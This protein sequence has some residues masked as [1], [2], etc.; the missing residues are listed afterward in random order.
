MSRIPTACEGTRTPAHFTKQKCPPAFLTPIRQAVLSALGGITL[1]AVQLGGLQLGGLLVVQGSAALA[2]SA[3]PISAHATCES[4][5]VDEPDNDGDECYTQPD[6]PKSQGDNCPQ[7]NT[8]ATSQPGQACGDPIQL[9]I[10]NSL[11]TAQDYMGAGAFPISIVRTYNSRATTSGP[12]GANWSL[13]FSA[14]VAS[15]STTQVKV[16]SDSGKVLTFNL[17]SGAWRPDADVNARLTQSKDASGNTSGWLF[18]TGTDN[19]D[20]FDAQGRLIRRANRAGLAQTLS[21][22]SQGR[23]SSVADPYGRTLTLAYD[24]QNRVAT[25]KDPSS[26]TYTYGYDSNNNLASVTYPDG[27]TRH[28]LYESTSFPHAMT[29]LVDENGVRFATWTYNSQGL[30]VSSEHAGG[31]D[32]VGINYD[33]SNG[34]STV[35]DALS[36]VTSYSYE[37]VAGVAHTMHV[38]QPSPIGGSNDWD[39]DANGNVSTYIDFLGR[40]TAYTYDLSR[41]LETSRT[42]AQGTSLARTITTTWHPTLRLP[43][44]ISEPGR[45][46]TFSYDSAGNLLQRSVSDSGSN[47]TRTWTYTYN[48]AGQV[49][50]ATDPNGNV[51]TLAYD[52]MGNLQSVQDALGHLTRYTYDADGRMTQ[53]TDPNGL[54]T[55]YTYDARGRLVSKA[56]GALSTSYGYDA[57]GDMTSVKWPSGYQITLNYDDAHR[58]TRVTDGLG[59]AIQY[60]LDAMSNRLTESRFD[61]SGTQVYVHNWTYDA[62]NRVATEVGA[63]GQTT[64]YGRDR[65]GNLTSIT[66]PLSHAR[67]FGYDALDRLDTIVD[68]RQGQTSIAHD[69]LNHIV[70]VTDPRGLQTSYEVDALGNTTAVQSPDT[71]DTAITHDAAGNVTTRTDAKGQVLQYTYDALNRVTQIMRADTQQLLVSY[72]YD[73]VDSTHTNGIG[74]LTSM[75]DEGGTTDWAYDVN[76]HVLKHRQTNGWRVQTTSYTYD[77][78]SGNLLTQTLPSAAKVVYTWTK[79]RVSSV[80]VQRSGLNIALMSN[81]QYQPFGPI[82]AWSWGNGVADARQY[83]QDGRVIADSVDSAIHYDAASRITDATLKGAISG[84]RT[85]AYDELDRLTSLVSADGSQNLSYSYDASGNRITSSNLG[86]SSTYAVDTNSNRLLSVSGA[87]AKALNYDAN[88]SVIQDGGVTLSYDAQGHMVQALASD[89]NTYTYKYNGL[90]QRVEK[91]SN[92]ALVDRMFDYDESG[93]LIGEYTGLNVLIQETIYLGNTPIAVITPVNASYLKTD[94][95]NAPRQA[96]YAGGTATWA[97]DAQGFGESAQANLGG[98]YNPRFPGQYLDTET[99]NFYNVNRTYSPLTGRYLQSDPI[100]LAGGLNTYAYAG[101]NPVQLSDPSGLCVYSLGLTGSIN[102]PLIGSVGLAGSWSVGIVWDSHG[103]VGLY[104]TSTK[105]G[106]GVGAGVGVGVSGAIYGGDV[107]ADFG[108]PFDN[109]S[110]GAGLGPYGSIDIFHDPSKPTSDSSGYGGGV[111]VGAGIAGSGSVT[112]TDTVVIPLGSAAAGN[113]SGHACPSSCF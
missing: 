98:S 99:G 84:T 7:V 93:H 92:G 42:E 83:D 107:I 9:T 56:E 112:R 31:A 95:R 110:I 108:G 58:L 80:L 111:T 41:N 40:K 72:T 54:I 82:G 62:L 106:S 64:T 60:T 73:Q 21:Y 5:N 1:S 81:I 77:A 96:E 14:S 79:G 26:R 94:Y 8:N 89:G 97:W 105:V 17:V 59:N 35:T 36:R 22:D 66:D 4:P 113:G 101:D 47:A 44:Q 24:S 27:K 20:T 63:S 25:I 50:T 29:G 67:T 71:G 34:I 37:T 2:L 15:I 76:G 46:T 86:Q 16:I 52:S 32:K 78:S 19:T 51:T 69:D 74:H 75:T 91:V 33:F 28:Y 6:I 68:A 18:Q 100:G 85:Y 43:T 65:N 55:T 57:V 23:L 61:A 13:G 45:V 3:M 11:Q 10:G 102:V 87:N 38:N 39:Y 70:S 48:A 109:S 88:G 104:G 30:A 103:N 49:V 53:A 90:G 12:L